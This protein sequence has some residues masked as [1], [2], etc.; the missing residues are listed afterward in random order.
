MHAGAA[1]WY[2]F[3][4]FVLEFWVCFGFRASDFKQARTVRACYDIAR[5]SAGIDESVFPGDRSP[6][7]Y[8]GDCKHPCHMAFQDFSP[9]AR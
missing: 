8:P 7:R 3:V 5:A 1:D 6:G 2:C 4:P 9:V